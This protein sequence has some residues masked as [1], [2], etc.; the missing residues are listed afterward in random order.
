MRNCICSGENNFENI[1]NMLVL[2]KQTPAVPALP[3]FLQ[4]PKTLAVAVALTFTVAFTVALALA[5]SIRRKS[6]L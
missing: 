3:F 5:F 4:L 1:A 6:A 2:Y